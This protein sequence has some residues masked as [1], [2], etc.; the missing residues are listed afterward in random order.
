M[1]RDTPDSGARRGPGRRRFGS[2]SLLAL[3]AGLGVAMG[4]WAASSIR[5]DEV[6]LLLPGFA[7]AD[8]PSW[9]AHVRGWIYE[10]GRDRVAVALLERRLRESLDLGP[11][12]FES[13][14][15][16][17]RADMFFVDNERGKRVS[18]TIGDRTVMLP[19]STPRG[20]FEDLVALTLAGRRSGDWIDVRTLPRAGDGRVFAGQIQ[21]V[22]PR[23]VSV[24]SDIDDTIKIS[25]VLDR[26]EL[27]ANTF[28]R[29]FQA[30]PGMPDLYRSWSAAGDVVFHYVS[31][32]PWQL[33]PSLADFLER[34]AFPRGSL[35]LRNF[36]LK[37]QSA[38]EFLQ[39]KTRE[40]KLSVIAPVM[41]AFPGR[42]FVLVGDSGEQDP[43]VYAALAAR[44]PSQVAAI[45][46]RDVRGQDITSPRF[47]ELYRDLPAGVVRRV[48]Q[49]PS[50]LDD[51]R[52][53]SLLPG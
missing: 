40:Y 27:A 34:E 47:V 28:A 15:F 37:D 44:F 51:F 6:V 22:G 52:I 14:L 11:G 10:P 21:L 35:H 33:F 24:I 13:Q 1:E 26:R 3:A 38:W 32:S 7:V 20:H 16:R 48:F 29:A 5:P 25:R 50:E 30:A 4:A 23:G 41:Q 46:I 53:G 31:G 18:V 9:S 17:A 36:S 42:R 2:A 49:H 19:S 43:E 39:D 8:G 12:E 45:L